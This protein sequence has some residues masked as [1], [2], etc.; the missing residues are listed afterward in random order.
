MARHL[1]RTASAA[2]LMGAECIITGI[3]S[4]IAQTITQL[5]I[6]L[7]GLITKSSLTDGLKVAFDLVGHK[8]A[9]K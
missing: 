7:S 9:P 1:I 3:S 2:K 6:D 5:G 4:R 8:V